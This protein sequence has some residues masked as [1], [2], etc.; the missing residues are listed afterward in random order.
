MS[1]LLDQTEINRARQ[2]GERALKLIDLS[3]QEERF[4]VWSAMLSLERVHGDDITRDAC[5]RRAVQGSDS[6]EVFIHLAE[7]HE[8]GADTERANAAFEAAAQ[9]FRQHSDVWSSWLS[10]LMARGDQP[11][12]KATLQRAMDALPRSLHADMVSKF[13]QLEFRHGSVERGR[14]NFDCLL[15][16]YPK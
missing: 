2:V 10:A 16:S 14:T 7:M 3:Q 9:K 8:H 4:N 1:F 6:K 15:A 13:A 5:F 12:A 11:S